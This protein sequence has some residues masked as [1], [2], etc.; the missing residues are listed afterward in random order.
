MHG[1]QTDGTRWQ[2][3][4]A[5]ESKVKKALESERAMRTWLLT[6]SLIMPGAAAT[7][8]CAYFLLA[9]WQALQN[10]HA[11]VSRL[12]VAHADLRDLFIAVS[13]EQRHRLNCFAEGI[14]LL[15][16]AILAGIGT[17]GLCCGPRK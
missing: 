11:N 6:L 2:G 7:A 10:A 17:H 4:S 14:G 5:K 12:I 16:G 15:L 3:T 8:V 1:C 9:D 13:A